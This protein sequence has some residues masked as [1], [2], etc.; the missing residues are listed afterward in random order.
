[1]NLRPPSSILIMYAGEPAALVGQRRF[2]FLGELRHLPPGDPTVRMVA[3]MAYYA[4]LI[5]GGEL[6]GPYA[7]IDAERFARLALLDPGAF[8]AYAGESDAL[9]AARFRIPVE[10]IAVARVEGDSDA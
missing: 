7:D 9:L 4:Q 8:A 5:L 10:Q 6:P 1:M 3:Y 2:S